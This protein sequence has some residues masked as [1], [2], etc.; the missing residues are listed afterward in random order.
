M[1]EDLGTGGDP[2]MQVP[3]SYDLAVKVLQDRRA[4]AF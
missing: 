1:K 4:E 2:Y 3:R